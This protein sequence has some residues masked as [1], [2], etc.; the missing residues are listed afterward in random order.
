M[1]DIDL[2]LVLIPGLPLLAAVVTAVFGKHVLGRQSHWPTVL[3]IA[4]SW[5]ASVALLVE[6]GRESRQ[7]ADAAA[8]MPAE[9]RPLGYE[10]VLRLWTWASVHDRSDGSVGNALRGVP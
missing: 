2:L 3:A 1:S 8:N 7:A 4:L 6:V 10:H 5:V 9:S